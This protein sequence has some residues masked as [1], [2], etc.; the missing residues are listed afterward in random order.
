MFR[1]GKR[2]S[3]FCEFLGEIE[4]FRGTQ[5]F[6]LAPAKRASVHGVI[7]SYGTLGKREYGSFPPAPLRLQRRQAKE[8]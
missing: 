4:A 8:A 5:P 1:I 6:G 3:H 7:T 2:R